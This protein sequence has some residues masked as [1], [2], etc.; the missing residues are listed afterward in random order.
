[1]AF[2][3]E[4]RWVIQPTRFALQTPQLQVDYLKCWQ[5]LGK[6]FNPTDR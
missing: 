6:R 3:F 2:V 4:T 5:G 1:M